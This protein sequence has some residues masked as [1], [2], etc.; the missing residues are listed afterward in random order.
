MK[1]WLLIGLAAILAGGGY[2]AWRTLRSGD[3]PEGFARSNG[4]IEGVEIDI[5][6]KSAGR[7]REILVRE[8]DFVKTDQVVAR[9]DTA[10]LEAQLREA[11]ARLRRA[12]IGIE[13]AKTMVRQR[14]ADRKAAVAV[15]AQ[16]EAELD[17][18]QRRLAR[19]EELAPRG[20]VPSSG[21]T[22][23]APVSS[24]AT[25]PSTSRQPRSQPRRRRSARPIRRWLTRR[26]TSRR[27]APPSSEFRQTSTTAHCGHHGTAASSFVLRNWA[28]CWPPGDGYSTWSILA[29]F[30]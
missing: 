1:R 28:K 6:T 5:S 19:S 25:R 13:T 29:T 7:I 3:L 12:Q 23:I 8:G 10:V 9:M 18:A 11:Q 22:M 26:R 30:T 20:A 27:Y 24:R 2:Y 15:V 17:A 21:L 16:R 4:R 14:E